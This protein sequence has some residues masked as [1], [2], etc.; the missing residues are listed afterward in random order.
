[1]LLADQEHLQGRWTDAQ[2]SDALGI[3]INTVA[4]IRRRFVLEGETPALNRR[5]RITPPHKPI[6]DGKAH[7]HL[8]AICCSSPPCGRTHWTIEL[9]VNE[10]KGRNIVTQISR[11]T[12]RRSLKKMNYVLGKNKD[13]ASPKVM[14]LDS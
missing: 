12:V 9:L 13:I 10:L 11:E 14:L 7:A 1:M 3:H 4:K 8:V 6:L 5:R 2:I